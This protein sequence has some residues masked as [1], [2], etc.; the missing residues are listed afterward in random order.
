MEPN[1]TRGGPKPSI[2]LF[3]LM[4]CIILVLLVVFTAYDSADRSL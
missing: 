4:A 2:D 1:S 3:M